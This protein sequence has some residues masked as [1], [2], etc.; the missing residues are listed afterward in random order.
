MIVD[1]K[2]SNKIKF[3]QGSEVLQEKQSVQEITKQKKEILLQC[4]AYEGLS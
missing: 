1:F 3:I 4:N 2:Y